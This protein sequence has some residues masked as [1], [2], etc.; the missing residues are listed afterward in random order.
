M[1]RAGLLILLILVTKGLFAQVGDY[2]VVI[3]VTG[4]GFAHMSTIYFDDESWDP[5][6]FPSY[7]WDP[8]CDAQLFLGNANQPHIF[9]RVV[10]PPLPLNNERLSING[11][12]LL[13]EPTDVSLGLLP[14]QL[15]EYTLSFKELSTIPA[16]VTVELED[17]ALSVTQNLLIDSTYVTWSAPSDEEN[18]FILHFNP[19][20]VT[21]LNRNVNDE[22]TKIYSEDGTVTISWSKSLS[23]DQMRVYDISGRTISIVRIS[24]FK[25]NVALSVGNYRSGLYIVELNGKNVDLER[26]K[27]RL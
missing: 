25:N 21:G 2:R 22:E 10:A 11:L 7:G 27:I 19:S 4:N 24:E 16:G 6:Q 14:G 15:A 20:T 1:K 18:R 13:F 23:Y 8:C 12:P 3:D 5:Q 26:V 9:T 17:L